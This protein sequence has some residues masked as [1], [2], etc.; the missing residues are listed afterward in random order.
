[1]PGEAKR[2]RSAQ[3]FTPAI[4]YSEELKAGRMKHE[5]YYYLYNKLDYQAF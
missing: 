3:S 1:M 4:S 2:R 5:I